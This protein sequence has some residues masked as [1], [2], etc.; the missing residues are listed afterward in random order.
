MVVF[1][2]HPSFLHY[3]QLAS[4][5]LAANMAEKVMT[6][7]TQNSPYYTLKRLNSWFSFRAVLRPNS[8]ERRLDVLIMPS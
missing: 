1:P 7:K 3:L 5:V 2:R 4:H 6:V 8:R